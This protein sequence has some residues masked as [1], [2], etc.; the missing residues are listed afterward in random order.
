MIIPI[1]SQRVAICRG[2]V[3]KLVNCENCKGAYAYRMGR[4]ARGEATNF[5]FL[6]SA[7]ADQKAAAEAHARLQKALIYD[8]DAVPCPLC[9]WL[10]TEMIPKARSQYALGIWTAGLALLICWIVALIGAMVLSFVG[11][12]GLGPVPGVGIALSVAGVCAFAG[13]ALLLA[14]VA[15]QRRHD[16]NAENPSIRVQ[17]GQ[18]RALPKEELDQVLKEYRSTILDESHGAG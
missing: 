3:I 5:L 14:R 9:G 13:I 11:P 10:Q 6:D 15:A 4:R 7:A 17:I 18:R 1:A 2:S 12:L 16:P 8:C